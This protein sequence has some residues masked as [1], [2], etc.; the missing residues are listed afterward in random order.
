MHHNAI[1]NNILKLIKKAGILRPRDLAS[2]GLP[3]TYLKR[4]SDEG[5]I[6]KIGHGLYTLE[7]SDMSESFELAE[8]AKK[9]PDGVIC[10]ISALQYHQLTTQIANEVWIAIDP[11]ARL[12]RKSQLPFKVV[13]FSGEALTKGFEIKRIDKVRV[14]IY[15]PAKTVADCFKYRNKI[16]LDVALESLHDCWKKRLATMDELW[17]YAKICR[18]S[19]IMRPYLESLV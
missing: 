4:L 17:I 8:V 9:I 7:D 3:R 12:P 5:L 11:K 10:L 18:V 13:R 2:L 16:G 1:K 6:K 19:N 14:R 15:C